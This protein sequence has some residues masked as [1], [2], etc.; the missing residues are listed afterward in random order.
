M[1]QTGNASGCPPIPRS[2]PSFPISPASS[3]GTIYRQPAMYSWEIPTKVTAATN[4]VDA[5]L[6]SLIS[7]QRALLMN[8]MPLPQVTG[9]PHPNMKAL[10]YDD[11]ETQNSI[12]PVSKVISDILHNTLISRLPERAGA[13]YI[14][15]SFLQWQIAPSQETFNNV[16]EWFQPRPAQLFNPHAMWVDMVPFYKLRDRIIDN[17]DLYETEEFQ[18][19]YCSSLNLN[20]PY[21][22][23]D[24]LEV[25][26]EGGGPGATEVRVSEQF[27]RH[28][29]NMSNWSLDA[30]FAMR[31]PELAD[32]CRF[33]EGGGKDDGSGQSS[34]ISR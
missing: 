34:P 32:V 28:C 27:K 10:I 33:T 22:D 17:Q 13:F 12:H 19:T 16:P 9:S 24:V 4:P 15:Y 18:E 3:H 5:L 21:R 30:R 6:L 31:Y 2:V 29:L 14:M 26:N 23:L 25:V 7:S 20:W 1:D 8:G 11:P